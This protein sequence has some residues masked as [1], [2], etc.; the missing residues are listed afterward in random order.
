MYIH[1]KSAV[2]V[3]KRDKDIENS[4][5]LLVLH[6]LLI[7]KV[8]KYNVSKSFQ[9]T[10]PLTMGVYTCI[11]NFGPDFRYHIQSQPKFIL[12]GASWLV[13]MCSF[14]LVL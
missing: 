5:F 4:Y 12:D 13:V 1:C 7:N 3:S 14:L 9:I 8:I 10:H 6:H 2:V 11:Y